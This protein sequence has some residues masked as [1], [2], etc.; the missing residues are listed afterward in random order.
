[1]RLPRKK[2]LIENVNLLYIDIPRIIQLSQVD[3]RAKIDGYL[4]VIYPGSQDTI[5]LKKGEMINAGTFIGAEKKPISVFKA[6]DRMRKKEDDGS[7]YYSEIDETLLKLLVAIFHFEPK[8][9][10]LSSKYTNIRKLF[11][12]IQKN[13]FEGFL[14][15]ELNNGLNFIEFSGENIGGCYFCDDV[16]EPLSEVLS[17]GDDQMIIESVISMIE[18]YGEEI[19]VNIFNKVDEIKMQISPAQI[20]MLEKVVNSIIE[21]VSKAIGMANTVDFMKLSLEETTEKYKFLK[22]IDL[23]NNTC[24][25]EKVFTAPDLF[26]KSIAEWINGFIDKASLS[27]GDKTFE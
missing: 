26:V 4:S 21:G 18:N 7:L 14:E 12:V 13:K 17:R 3:R 16:E 8:H 24:K 9:K 11:E 1:M 20:Q 10:N 5:F 15:F 23:S 27:L 2:I 22:D 19:L 6:L 25:M